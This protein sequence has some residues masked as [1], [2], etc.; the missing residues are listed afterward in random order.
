MS[1]FD[2]PLARCEDFHTLVLTDETQAEC[3]HEH[4]C[5]PGH[6]C[7]LDTYF[8][9]DSGISEEASAVALNASH[10]AKLPH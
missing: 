5:P 1:I 4:D 3:A 8:T 6:K 10:Q 7:P 9:K 2:A